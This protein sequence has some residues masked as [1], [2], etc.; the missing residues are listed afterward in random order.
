MQSSGC[1]PTADVTGQ[2][3]LALAEPVPDPDNEHVFAT[4]LAGAA[5]A[6]VTFN[7]KDFPAGVAGDLGIEIR[8]PDAFLVNIIDLD[9]AR[10]LKALRMQRE[11]L[12]NPPM[13]ADEFLRRLGA[14]GLMQTQL[15]LTSLIGLL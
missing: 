1:S 4:A 14:A 8:H 5:D 12:K 7:I 11:A 6:I 15:R 13:A 2:D 10:A 3:H 9:P